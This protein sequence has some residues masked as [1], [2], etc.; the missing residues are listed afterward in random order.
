MFEIL[1]D[2]E[3]PWEGVTN[4]L[5]MNAITRGQRPQIECIK[6]LYSKETVTAATNLIKICWNS[7]CSVRPT[8]VE[9][10]MDRVLP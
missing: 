10:S 7:S 2:K 3:S 1:S 6:D 8:S 4:E 5:L 9:V